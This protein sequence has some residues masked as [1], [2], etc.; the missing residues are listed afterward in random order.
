VQN[1]NTFEIGDW[2]V[3]NNYGVGEIRKIEER[4]LHG[5]LESCYKVRTKNAIYWLPVARSDN[6]RVRRVV[7][8][9]R[10][11]KALTV[12]KSAPENMTNNYRSREAR[13]KK[14]IFESGSLV[15]MAELLRDL[16][17]RG[18][19]K[20][21]NTTERNAIEKLEERFIREWSAS[22]EVS[23]D[24]ARSGFQEI[25]VNNFLSS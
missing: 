25:I 13:I 19:S 21:L 6:P 22:R 16:L 4:P 18:K 3:H 2:I 1:Q 23:I 8:K 15:K 7:N 9:D 11:K 14:V 12:L 10:L 17:A 20:K 24:K 5:E